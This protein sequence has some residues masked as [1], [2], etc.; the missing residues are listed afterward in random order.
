MVLLAPELR[1]LV[2][3]DQFRLN[4]NGVPTLHHPPSEHGFHAQLMANL[5]WIDLL[6]FVAKDR[7][8][9]Y[10]S[11]SP[12]LRK[13]VDKAFGN[14]VGKIIAICIAARIDKRQHGY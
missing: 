5:L 7:A 10:D 3:I 11:E 13:G 2:Y 12:E 9:R 14:S 8:A 6:T 4:I 1:I